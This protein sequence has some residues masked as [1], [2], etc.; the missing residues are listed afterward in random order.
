M[1][2][3]QLSNYAIERIFE[4]GYDPNDSGLRLALLYSH[5]PTDISTESVAPGAKVALD[6]DDIMIG[7]VQ[8][9][10]DGKFRP[11][12]GGYLGATHFR[13]DDFDNELRFAFGVGVGT[14]Y[15]FTENFG[16]RLDLRGFGT[17]MGGDTGFL[18]VNSNCL[19]NWSGDIMWQGEVAGS[20]F[21]SF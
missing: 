5:Q 10:Y 9:L 21:I 12:V 14:N 7:A 1:N 16:L 19:V 3:D 13:P 18:C 17:F 4:L 8:E 6:I 20:I 2:A 11:F 15:Y